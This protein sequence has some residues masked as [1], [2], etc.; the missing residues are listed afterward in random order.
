MKANELLAHLE[1]LG[2]D[3]S[4]CQ[5]KLRVGAARGLLSEELKSEIGAQKAELLTLLAGRSR[6]QA[7]FHNTASIESETE[8]EFSLSFAQRRIWFLEQLQPGNS[9]Y[10]LNASFVIDD[11]LDVAALENAINDV[12][13]R[14]TALRTVFR[15]IN[16]EPIQVVRPFQ[17]IRL[18][19]IDLS[20]LSQD[21]LSKEVQRVA[22]VEAVVPF[23]LVAGPL[24]RAKLLVLGPRKHL[25]LFSIHHIVSDNW[26][27]GIFQEELTKYYQV[28]R[29]GG[30]PDR[31]QLPIQYG[32][33]AMRENARLAGR[34]LDQIL[35]Y[36]YTRLAGAPPILD[37][38]TDKPRPPQQT[39]NGAVL[40]FRLPLDLSDALRRL[41]RRERATLYMV[42]LAT[43]KALLYRYSGQ[44]DIVVGTAVANRPVSQLEKLIGL[45]VNT[46]PIRSDLG[47]DP[48][49]QSLISQV[50]ETVLDAQAH[51]DLP[52]EKLV[53]KLRP[54]R[55]MAWSPVFQ[56]T[57]VLQNTPLSSSFYNFSSGTAMFDLT[58]FVWDDPAG[59]AGSFEYNT[60][61][62]EP[63]TIERMSK[64]FLALAKGIIA[65]PEHRL[66]ELPLLEEDERQQLLFEWNRTQAN[67]ALDRCLH[68]LF[69]TQ[70][71]RVGGAIAVIFEDEALTYQELNR[72]A[73]QLG[74]HL[75]SLG[76]GPESLVAI[77][78]ERSLEMVVG[79]LGILKAGGAYLPLDPSYPRERL[80]F[81]LDDARPR[82]LLT[83][84][85]LFKELPTHGTQVVYLDVDWER[86][87][88]ERAE[89]LTGWAE[90]ENLAYVIYTSG[91]TGLPKGTLVTHRAI[92]N[93]LQWRQ[94]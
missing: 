32:E 71:E 78:V 81:M 84:G 67:Y 11:A 26:S 60:D 16:G 85:H 69:E 10:N 42:L 57:F 13:Q 93:H 75:R 77:C 51:R 19:R 4:V 72:R 36:W 63:D 58:L 27:L 25:L 49:I 15:E 66:S 37:L 55:N 91:S 76:V 41:A 14:Q 90:A 86:I 47:G 33:Y 74:R 79:L 89:N 22:E 61:L 92:C 50:R 39:F 1:M 35:D 20:H 3:L 7:A 53:E 73:N 48:T 40:G 44:T 80:S 65:N 17:A 62:F 56:V 29:A 64:H 24:F 54:E 83:Q 82:V 46:L 6:G 68:E 8:Q 45:F 43:F 87:A 21:E 2:A 52:F 59:I 18:C 5:G 28:Y 88:R 12:L 70:V 23:D 9:A 94:Q 38:P 34:E 31:I 30:K